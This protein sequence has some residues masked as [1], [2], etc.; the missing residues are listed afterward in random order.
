MI[1]CSYRY[2]KH[3]I[4]AQK[5]LEDFDNRF[6]LVSQRKYN[7]KIV[8][9]KVI[10]PEGVTVTVQILTD[11]SEPVIDKNTGEI[12]DDN[13]YETFDATIL[14]AS[15]P[16]PLKKGDIVSLLNFATDNS[17]YVDFNLILRFK[18]IKKVED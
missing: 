6:L 2:I 9:G 18:G 1:K 8:D 13:V 5:L 17:Y 16:L 15:Y 4:D 10:T 3:V 14:G 11:R 7:G 12:M